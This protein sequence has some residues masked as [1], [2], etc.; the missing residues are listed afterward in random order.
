M[1][2]R[3]LSALL[4]LCLLIVSVCENVIVVGCRVDDGVTSC[5]DLCSVPAGAEVVLFSGDVLVLSCLP[6]SVKVG[7]DS[8]Q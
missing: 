3:G 8:G 4:W 2:M 6:T 7:I 1:A 5:H